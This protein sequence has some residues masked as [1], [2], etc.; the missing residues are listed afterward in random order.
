M[1]WCTRCRLVTTPYSPTPRIQATT[2]NGKTCI[3]LPPLPD[4]QRLVQQLAD[5]EDERR[6]HLDPD[7]EADQRDRPGRADRAGH[8]AERQVVLQ[9][10]QAHRHRADP[11]RVEAG[12]AHRL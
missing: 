2:M 3:S 10:G 1:I 8:L 9:V 6:G 5:D 11:Y 12:R 4:Q 7:E